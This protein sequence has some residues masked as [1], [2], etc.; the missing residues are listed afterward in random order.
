[1]MTQVKDPSLYDRGSYQNQTLLP[2]TTIAELPAISM[3]NFVPSE[4]REVPVV[5]V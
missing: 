4:R 1:M 2:V 3:P 5:N